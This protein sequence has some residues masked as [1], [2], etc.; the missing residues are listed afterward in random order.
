MNPL[1]AATEDGKRERAAAAPR[2][3]LSLSGGKDSAA[4]AIYMR[5]R[6]P[7]MEYIFH[8]TDKELPETYDYLARLEAVLGKPIAKT[9]PVDT[10]DHWLAVYGGM[11]PSNHRRWCTKM[12]KLKP[13]ETYVG[14]GQ[15]INYVGL[16][17]DE[18]RIGY[19]STKPNITAV[20]P[21]REEGLVRRDII[22]ILEDSGL[23]LPPYMAWGRSR[24]GCYFCFYQQKIE[25]VRL[26][27]THKDLFD[28]AKAYEEKSVASGEQF[29]WCQNETLAELE[30]PERILQIK[31]NWE[32]SQARARA[33][34]KNI[35]LVETVGGLEPQDDP[36]LREG[37]LIC[38]L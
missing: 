3:V 2:H 12:L 1:T 8:D 10:F 17:A 5:D 15:V 35:P 20:Y 32:A 11:L 25:W 26:H 37:C 19:I 36:H 38:S 27:E 24:S 16:R 6:V 33:K 28:L 13:F 7:E 4:L 30:R 14:D 29:Y 34:R 21:F 31:E 9:S 22:R 18:K 23:G